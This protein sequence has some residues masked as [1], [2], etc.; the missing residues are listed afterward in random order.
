MTTELTFATSER[1]DGVLVL[2][3]AG[4]ID[5]SNAEAFSV[6]LTETHREAGAGS[7]VVDL[8]RIGY[9]DSAGLAV[10]F[11]HVEQLEL[12]AAPLLAPVLAIAGLDDITTIK[13]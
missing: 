10:L 1:P 13:G 12:V 8:T 7:F 9:L 3:V 11:R 4:E 2:A 5:M 6:A